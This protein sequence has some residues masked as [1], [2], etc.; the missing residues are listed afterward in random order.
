VERTGLRP[1]SFSW[2]PEVGAWIC[3]DCRR[4]KKQRCSVIDRLACQPLPTG[5]META[6]IHPSHQV[7]A[8]PVARGLT[9]VVFCRRCGLYTQARL[10][11]L[12]APCKADKSSSAF[13]RFS[14]TI[15]AGIH[16]RTKSSLGRAYSLGVAIKVAS[17]VADPG[18]PEVVGSP[19]L[20]PRAAPS[21]PGFPDPDDP[22]P[23]PAAVD[24][25]PDAP[26]QPDDVEAFLDDPDLCA[27][28][29]YDG[30]L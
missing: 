4:W 7:F 11:K 2:E 13:R 30:S 17:A 14:S 9:S 24:S 23:E 27:F 5:S 15:A 18:R 29:G 3:S 21:A 6:K 1:H 12:K 25:L 22:F 28:F 16:P 20:S 19:G 10:S 8:R 26:M